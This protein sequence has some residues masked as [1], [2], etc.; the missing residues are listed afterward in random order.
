MQKSKS[1][2]KTTTAGNAPT[3]TTFQKVSLYLLTFS[4]L[5]FL[6]EEVSKNLKY[7]LPYILIISRPPWR[8]TKL[9]AFR[10]LEISNWDR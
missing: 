10:H 9:L 1:G 7:F 2:A 6:G 4:I 8:Y 3:I 5:S